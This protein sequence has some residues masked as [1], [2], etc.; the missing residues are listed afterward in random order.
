MV[1]IC[2]GYEWPKFGLNWRSFGWV[3]RFICLGGGGCCLGL[4]R[5]WPRL[6]KRSEPSKGAEARS[7]PS[8][9]LDSQNDRQQHPPSQK[10]LPTTQ[11]DESEPEILSSWS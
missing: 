5:F 10:Q 11:T 4:S 9:G 3:L 8:V 1:E 6:Q 7:R 2:V